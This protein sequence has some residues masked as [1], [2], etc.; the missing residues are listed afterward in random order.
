[1]GGARSIIINVFISGNFMVLNGKM[2]FITQSALFDL[3]SR[4]PQKNSSAKINSH[5]N[6]PEQI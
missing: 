6:G 2:P 1:M 5:F 3:A 4:N